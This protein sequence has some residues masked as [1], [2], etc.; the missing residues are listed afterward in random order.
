MACKGGVDPEAIV[1]G[2]E[3]YALECQRKNIAG[4]EKVAQAVTF[5][6]QQRWKDYP[7][8]TETPAAP[9]ELE[10]GHGRFY[11][12]IVKRLG[13]QVATSWFRGLRLVRI[14]GDVLHLTAPTKF[15][16]DRIH[17]FYDAELLLAVHSV[18]PS[19][20]LVEVA[21]ADKA[22]A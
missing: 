10:P 11:P 13:E 7:P 2:A 1:G 16:A 3:R 15:V 17:S 21:V 14:E 22:A 5:L 19:I 4:T 12:A 20:N 18:D 9:V 6:S 8:A